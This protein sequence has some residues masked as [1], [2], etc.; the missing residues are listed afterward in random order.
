[1]L[2][3]VTADAD[4]DVQMETESDPSGHCLTKFEPLSD[5]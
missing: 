4:G 5:L 2:V 3:L 1:M